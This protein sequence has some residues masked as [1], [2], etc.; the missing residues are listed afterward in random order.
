MEQYTQSGSF[1]VIGTFQPG[2]EK[3]LQ[4]FLNVISTRRLRASV[5]PWLPE[6]DRQL[7]ELPLTKEQKSY[8]AELN[9]T[10][11]IN[12]TDVNAINILAKLVKIRQILL[13][14]VLLGLKGSS[15]KID[16][17]KQYLKDYPEK[18]VLIF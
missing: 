14:P 12:G 6:K 2:K 11:E 17:I 9:S 1:S 18:K 8:I 13:S 3:E 15:P 7:I 5:M 10:F 16:W 4:E